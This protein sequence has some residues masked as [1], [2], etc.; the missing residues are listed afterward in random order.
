M[1][2]VPS[3]GGKVTVRYGSDAVCLVSAIPNSGFTV[4]TAQTDAQ[5]LTVTFS[6]DSHRSEITATTVPVDRW[7][8]RE[9]SF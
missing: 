5:T 2:T 8:V 9:S 6:A 7:S 3:T 4:S 1:H